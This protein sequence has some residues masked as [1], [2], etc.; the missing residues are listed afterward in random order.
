ME[1]YIRIDAYVADTLMRD[2][3][4]HDRRA[5]AY[6]AYLALL[7]A[8]RGR[9]VALS[10]QQLAERT[11]LSKRAVQH[12]ITHLNRRGLLR[13]ARRGGTEPALMEPLTPW[14]G[15]DAPTA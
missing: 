11:G 3:V 1:S 4:G 12:A 5:S 7:S 14:R 8:G 15:R 6:L 9:P 10:H 2:L 13:I